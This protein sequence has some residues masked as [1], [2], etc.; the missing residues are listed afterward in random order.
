MLVCQIELLSKAHCNQTLNFSTCNFWGCFVF[1]E[2][3]DLTWDINE[4]QVILKFSYT[5]LLNTS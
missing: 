1:T 2:V 3:T 5:L 4:E